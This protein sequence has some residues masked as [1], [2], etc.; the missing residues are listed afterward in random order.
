MKKRFSPLH[1]IFVVLTISIAGIASAQDATCPCFDAKELKRESRFVRDMAEIEGITTPRLVLEVDRVYESDKISAR[2][3]YETYEPYDTFTNAIVRE[4]LV[5]SER[6]TYC[7]HGFWYLD[8]RQHPT[9]EV[10]NLTE[11]QVAA[12]LAEMAEALPKVI[13]DEE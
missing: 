7:F 11:K 1:S 2:F 10:H 12:C 6:G 13:K 9:T 5:L 3:V 8:T 4:D